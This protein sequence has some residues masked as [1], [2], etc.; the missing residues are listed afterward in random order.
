M[1][2]KM[3]VETKKMIPKTMNKNE[4]NENDETDKNENDE[5]DIDEN[6]DMAGNDLI[7]SAELLLSVSQRRMRCAVITTVAS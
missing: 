2:M 7:T 5:D 1:V 4:K 3:F 6:F